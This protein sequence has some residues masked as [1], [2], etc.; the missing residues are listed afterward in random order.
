MPPLADTLH[1]ARHG[2]W[3]EI[4]TDRLLRNLSAIRSLQRPGTHVLAVIKANAYGHG[5][6]GIAEILAPYVDY[7]GVSSV[8]EV[9][10]LKEGKIQTPLFLM[11][12]LLPE[13]M[14]QVLLDGVTL[15]LSSWEEASTLNDASLAAGRRAKVHIKID[16]GMGRLGIPFGEALKTVKKIAQLPALELEGLFTH[17][18]SAEAEDGFTRN[19]V[20]D[21]SL[22]MQ[23]LEMEGLRFHFRHAAN[24]AGSVQ[25]KTPA[26]NMIRPGLMLYGAYPDPSL[27]SSVSVAPV[28]SLK[29]RLIS[30]KRIHEGQSV[31]YGRTFTAACP[32]TIGLLPVGYSLGFPVRASGQASVLYQGERVPLVGRV[33]MDYLAVDLGNRNAHVGDEVTLIGQELN[34][35]ITVEDLAAWAGTIPYEILT[36]LSPEIPRLFF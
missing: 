8:R 13:E 11:A 22:L 16:T 7:L 12:R 2:A 6:T 24:S 19:Q 23:A 10:E 9:F 21:F 17:F 15:S 1:R 26:L 33:S 30:V 14:P 5:L 31:G 3:I 34:Q 20:A 36:G 4:H 35:E 32:T 29:A 28:M 18:P 25:I 27:H